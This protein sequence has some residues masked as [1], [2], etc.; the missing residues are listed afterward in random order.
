[1]KR[2]QIHLKTKI[3]RSY[4]NYTH[5]TQNYWSRKFDLDLKLTCFI[6]KK[7]FIGLKIRRVFF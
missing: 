7:R 3:E 6:L 2:N 4:Q 5:Q 1:M